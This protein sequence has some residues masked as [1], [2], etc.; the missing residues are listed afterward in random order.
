MAPGETGSGVLQGL[1]IAVIQFTSLICYRVGRRAN[2]V[3]KM[4]A[5][6][7]FVPRCKRCPTSGPESYKTPDYLK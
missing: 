2:P 1:K 3:P 4:A 6:L 7:D 5:L